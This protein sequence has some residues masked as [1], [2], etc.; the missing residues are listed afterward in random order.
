MKTKL[1]LKDWQKLLVPEFTISAICIED[2]MVRV[3]CFDKKIN[4]IVKAGKYT[5]PAGIIE[6][7]ILKKKIL[8]LL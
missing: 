1:N 5:L 2:R 8:P 6:E 7:G 4:K 3:F